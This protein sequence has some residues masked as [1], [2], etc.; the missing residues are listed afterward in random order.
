MF[1]N[2]EQPSRLDT[3][4]DQVLAGV[5]WLEPVLLN[6]R[7]WNENTKQRIPIVDA[8]MVDA[9]GFLEWFLVIG[10][11]RMYAIRAGAVNLTIGADR[12]R[13]RPAN[14][15]GCN[16]WF[17]PRVVV[18]KTTRGRPGNIDVLGIGSRGRGDDQD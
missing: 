17:T 13:S 6:P 2:K 12:D 9:L 10:P 3:N 15:K 1:P 8:S 5:D 16:Q 11:A 18:A 7:L 4:Q 14:G